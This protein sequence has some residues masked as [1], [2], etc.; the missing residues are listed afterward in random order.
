MLPRLF[1]PQPL[2]APTPEEFPPDQEP[3]HEDEPEHRRVIIIGP[4]GEEETDDSRDN[5]SEK[6]PVI[7]DMK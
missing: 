2:Y 4:D 3:S 1:E 5:K 7:I 6:R